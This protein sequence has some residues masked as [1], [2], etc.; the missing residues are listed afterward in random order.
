YPAAMDHVFSV[1]ATQQNDTVAGFSRRGSTVDIA[2]PGNGLVTTQVGG[3]YGLA[4]GTSLAAPLVSAAAALVIAQGDEP[5]PD[6]VAAQ[7]VR[8]G[9]PISDG[10]GGVIRRLNA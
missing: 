2:A 10:A 7:L 6:A 8:T 4:S 1:A 3:G 5:S 9:L